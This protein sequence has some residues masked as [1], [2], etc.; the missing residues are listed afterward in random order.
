MTLREI[1]YG[2]ADYHAECSLR[3]EVLR[4]PLGLNLYDEDLERERDQW[5]FG[6]FDDNGQLIGCAIVVPLSSNEARIRQM[7]VAADYQGRGHGR[8]ILEELER[9]LTAMGFRHFVLHARQSAT[10]FYEKLGYSPVGE[11][12]WEVKIPHAMMEKSV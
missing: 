2:S 11:T 8:A 4:I 6:L 7:A 5:H 9:R 12:F 3:Q 10:G 1:T